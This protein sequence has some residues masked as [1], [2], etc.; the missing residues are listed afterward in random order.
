[1]KKDGKKQDSQQVEVKVS[2]LLEVDV[3]AEQDLGRDRNV[4]EK[5]KNNYIKLES[6][7]FC[8]MNLAFNNYQQEVV[9]FYIKAV[10]RH[11]QALLQL[12]GRIPH[13]NQNKHS[14]EQKEQ[15]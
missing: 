13:N 4:K 6:E 5:D 15:K 10:L 8:S 1:M 14:K 9:E 3:G 7:G 12:N 2:R 11:I